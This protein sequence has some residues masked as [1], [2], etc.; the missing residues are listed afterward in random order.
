MADYSPNFV[1]P[2]YATPEQLATQRAYAAELTKRSGEAVNRP[3]GALGN[4]ITALT[5]G[6][7]RNRANEMQSQAAGQ[8]SSDV[9][10]LIAQLQ[11]GQPI[12][13]ATAGRVYANP[14]AAPEHRA[15]IG[16]LI[17]PKQGEDVAGRPTMTS[18]AAGQQAVPVGPGIQPGIR[19]ALSVPDASISAVPQPAPPLPGAP[20]SMVTP[21]GVTRLDPAATDAWRRSTPLPPGVAPAGP[22]A[23]ASPP[24]APPAAVPNLPMNID[25]LAAKGRELAA[26]RTLTQGGA[27]AEGG[28]IKQDVENAALAPETLKGLGIIKDNIAKFGDKITFGPTSQFTNELKRLAANYAPGPMKDQLSALAAADSIEKVNLGLAG[29]LAKQVGSGTQGELFKAMGSVPGMEKSKEG[30]V[31]LIDMLQQSASKQQALGKLYADNRGNLAAYQAARQK[32]LTEHPVVNPLTGNPIEMDIEAARK[33]AP[34]ANTATGPA[35]GTIFNG[36]RFKG[37][38]PKDKANWEPIT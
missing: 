13:P 1:N 20:R 31:A 28:V 25:Q 3:T 23:G 30:A 22:Q 7:E 37:G 15:L 9:S 10:A 16:A 26:A 4:M 14:M 38:N 35:Q 36:Y 6:L 21:P 27:E 19:P 29:A 34:A 17:T 18:P 8:N 32:Y 5:A 33:N 2:Q 12:D 11:K 24:A